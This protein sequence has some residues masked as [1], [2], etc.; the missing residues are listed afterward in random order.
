MRKQVFILLLVVMFGFMGASISYPI[1][2][3]LFLNPGEHGLI[4]ATWSFS[5]RSILLGLTLAAYPFGQFIGTPWLGSLSDHFGRKKLL[6]ISMLGTGICYVLSGLSIHFELVG[7]LVLSRLLTGFLEGNLA[8]AQASIVD[9]PINKNK[10]L[11]ALSAMSSL[12]Y[13]FGPLLGGALSD[14]RL[15]SWFTF[16]LPFY[17]ASGIVIFTALMLFFW[18][19]ETL[20]SKKI[21]PKSLISQFNIISRLRV[22]LQDHNLK[23]L[24]IGGFFLYLAIDTYYVFYPVLLVM[25]WQMSASQIAFFNV[26]LSIA[27]TVGSFL[28]P[29]FL[30]RKNA[31]RSGLC[32]M[33]AIFPLTFICLLITSHSHYLYWEFTVIGLSYGAASTF[34]TVLLSDG[35]A[36]NQQGEIM[37]VRWGLRMLGDAI[38]CI[39][40]G[41]LVTIAAHLPI[42][43]AT[44]FAII[45]LCFFLKKCL[46]L[47]TFPVTYTKNSR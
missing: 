22:L 2:A 21:M 10:S 13:V 27:L 34:H 17:M 39:L 33:T 12:G 38:N 35:V 30:T 4:S 31:I 8:I 29:A 37:G 15:V 6:I 18:C 7:L 23:K 26:T 40:G 28:I 47:E 20:V 19:K 25:H 45:G 46:P 1:F 41:L 42:I 3:P 11:G 36:N 32:F 5:A 43:M 14:S 9:L 24:L 16:S 44:I